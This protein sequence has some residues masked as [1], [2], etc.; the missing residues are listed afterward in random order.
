MKAFG[1]RPTY[2]I[3]AVMSLLTGLIYLVFNLTYLM[4]RPQVEGNDI[5]KK[6][7]KSKLQSNINDASHDLEE[8]KSR[9]EKIALETQQEPYIVEDIE[10]I[11][12]A[13]NLDIIESVQDDNDEQNLEDGS[14]ESSRIRQRHTQQNG[15]VNPA[16]EDD[17]HDGCTV[18]VEEEP[19]NKK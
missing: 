16:F 12:N 7:S 13:K 1:T 15:T 14:K 5:V 4:K 6:T 2:Q 11:N 19:K 9:K 3:F 18:T 17:G 8:N 10:A